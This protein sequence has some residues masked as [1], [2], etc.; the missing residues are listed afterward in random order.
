MAAIIGNLPI[1]ILAQAPNCE[2]VEI[3]TYELPIH[4]GPATPA[5]ENSVNVHVT[6]GD[7][8]PERLARIVTRRLENAANIN[9]SL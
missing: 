4:I 1:K 3:G 2:P 8:D 7:L 9:N 6:V 5:G